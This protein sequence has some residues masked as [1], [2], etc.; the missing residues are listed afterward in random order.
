MLT[1]ARWRSTRMLPSLISRRA[2][3]SLGSS[4]CCPR[5][6]STARCAGGS[7]SMAV[8]TC[9]RTLRPSTCLSG[10]QLI[11]KFGQIS[12]AAA[13][14]EGVCKAVAV[15]CIVEKHGSSI[16]FREGSGLVE[17]D[18]VDPASQGA[19]SLE[20]IDPAE[21]RDPRILYDF[22]GHIT[23]SDDAGRKN[24]SS[25]HCAAETGSRTQPDPLRSAVAASPVHRFPI[26]PQP[27]R[28]VSERY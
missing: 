13:A 19:S 16:T 5:S 21:H 2:Q 4:S 1:R 12:P 25:R 26:S 15:G 20:E 3:T 18:S 27:L 23:A 11:P 6:I 22:F 10:G 14:V 8:S 17:E 28:T 9:L 24:E 7:A